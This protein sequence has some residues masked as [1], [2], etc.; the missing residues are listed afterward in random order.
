MTLCPQPDA[1]GVYIHVPYCRTICPYCDFNRRRLDGPVPQAY[2]DALR[3]EIAGFDGPRRAA[4]LLTPDDLAAI[5][6]AIRSRFDL[7]AD[8]EI[9]IEANPDDVTPALVAAWREA[10]VNRVSLGVQSFDDRVLRFL[11]RRHDAAGAEAA[12]AAVAEVFGNW[13]LDLMFGGEPVD[14]WQ[15]T[16]ERAR[17][18]A[19]A[20]VSAYGLTYEPGTPFE[21][22]ADSAVDDAAWLRL[23]R[24]AE[25]ALDGYDRYEISNYA[26]PGRQCVHNLIYWRNES[27]AGFGPGAY[28][29]VG[30]VR[31]RNGTVE[32]EYLSDPGRKIERLVLTEAEQRV[33]TV[34]QHLRLREGLPRARYRARFGDD[35]LTAHG[36]A[37]ARLERDGLIRVTDEAIAPTARGFELNNEIGLTLVG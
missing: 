10:G 31:A 25:A 23:Y 2:V 15:A 5:L 26:R 30:G 7:P 17:R 16:L 24:Q 34:I 35:P 13:S 36:A 29:Y 11:G 32:R 37:F 3:R 33:E 14:A 28:S 22:R 8:A 9:S 19:P 18:W 20:H 27:Y 4:S 6:S 1:V 21:M 12:C